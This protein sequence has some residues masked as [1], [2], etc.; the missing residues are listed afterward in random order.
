M[1]RRRSHAPPII[2]G[3]EKEDIELTFRGL[4]KE[5]W[6]RGGR[7]L[8]RLCS[9]ARV[10]G[11]GGGGDGGGLCGGDGEWHSGGDEEWRWAE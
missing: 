9:C 11:G 10:S 4:R 3:L 5:L 6:F 8:A 1:R 7:C 2:R